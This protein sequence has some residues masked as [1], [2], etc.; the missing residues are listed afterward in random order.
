MIE[1]RGD[2]RIEEGNLNVVSPTLMG[3][4]IQV[5]TKWQLSTMHIFTRPLKGPSPVVKVPWIGLWNV[6]D[7]HGDPIE[8]CYNIE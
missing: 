4:P 3:S 6:Q 8:S 1:E 2:T 5:P 7:R